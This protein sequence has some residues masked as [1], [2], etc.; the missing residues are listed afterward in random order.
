M[1]Q[2]DWNERYTTGDTPWDTGKPNPYLVEF[3]R[4]CFTARGRALDVGCGTGTNALW[5]ASGGFSVLGVDVS[6]VAVE[7][8]RE[9]VAGTDLD[10]RF[11]SLDFLND[12]VPGGPFDLVFDFGCLHLF[13]KTGDRAHFAERVASM[14]APTGRWLSIIGSTEG[15]ERDYGP[16]RRSA[17]DVMG[18]IEPAL[19]IVEFRAIE[20]H[21]N[22]PEPVAAWLC[23]S[24]PREVPA[25]P[26]TRRD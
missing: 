6:S 25:A 4:S 24:R 12:D 17:R 26:S 3:I 23:L 15:P 20:I 18:A 8:A 14:L 16:P 2:P 7:R 11:E 9:K 13:D 10:C 21:A 19:E 5:L 1:P 22:L